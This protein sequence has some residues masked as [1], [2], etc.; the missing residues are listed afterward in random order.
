MSNLYIETS[1]VNYLFDYVF[2]LPQNSSVKTKALQ[3]QK[4][5]KWYISAITLWEIFLTKNEKRRFDLLDF[6]RCLFYD[7]LIPSPEEIIINYIKNGCPKIEK[8]YELKSNSL[9]SKEW[10][11]SCQDLNYAFQPDREQIEE[12][13]KEIRLISEI[14]HTPLLVPKSIYDLNNAETKLTNDF[15]KYVFNKI[16]KYYGENLDNETINFIQITIK[17]TLILLCYGIGFDQPIIESFWNSIGKL[18]PLQRLDY[19]IE[20]YPELFYRGPITNISKMILIQQPKIG[21][22]LYFDSLHSSYITYSDLYMTN[23]RHFINFKV[24]HQKDPNMNKIIDVRTITF[25]NE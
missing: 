21:R 5:R 15:L 23:D 10:T 7:Y 19:T 13:T 9:F 17:V 1:A 11:R 2:S 18:E 22:G 24:A 3:M 8:Q 20:K 25:H 12:R 14:F 16:S 6:S 4:G